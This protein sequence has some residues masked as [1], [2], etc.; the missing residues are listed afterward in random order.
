MTEPDP[1]CGPCRK[2]IIDQAIE[3]RLALALEYQAQQQKAQVPLIPIESLNAYL[4]GLTMR[5]ADTATT[6]SNVTLITAV[7]STSA[8]RADSPGPRGC[9]TPYADIADD[10]DKESDGISEL[11]M[12]ELFD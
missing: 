12:Q 1:A 10:E 8:T 5:A 3:Q 9:S 6:S 2:R 7:A 11:E 4:Q